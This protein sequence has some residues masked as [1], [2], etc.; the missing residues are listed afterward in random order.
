MSRLCC[1]E[2]ERES[3]GTSEKIEPRKKRSLEEN[4]RT[5]FT[6]NASDFLNNSVLR[7]KTGVLKDAIQPFIKIIIR[8]KL[9]VKI[10]DV[11][12]WLI[13]F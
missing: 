13:M 9:I 1:A 2:S 4:K 10:K 7:A 3:E 8:L 11:D 6:S 5:T 12:F